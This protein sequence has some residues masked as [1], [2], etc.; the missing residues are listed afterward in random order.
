MLSL[1]EELGGRRVEGG[2]K[3]KEREGRR[4]GWPIIFR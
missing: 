1:D 3:K 2:R 4:G